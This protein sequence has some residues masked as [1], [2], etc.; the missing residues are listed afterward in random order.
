MNNFSE[1]LD[2][3]PYLEINI[4]GI[5]TCGPMTWSVTVPLVIT[6]TAYRTTTVDGFLIEDWQGETTE[7][8][9]RFDTVVPFYQWKHH[10][11][12]QGWLFYQNAWR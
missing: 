6:L 11:T 10:A 7:H 8:R 2:T 12:A 5:T 3:K 1:L 4:D 9:W